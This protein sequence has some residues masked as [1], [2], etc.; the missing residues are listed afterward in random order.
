MAPAL[1][2]RKVVLNF[3]FKLWLLT[4]VLSLALGPLNLLL[5]PLFCIFVV[6]LDFDPWLRTMDFEVTW[7]GPLADE[8]SRVADAVTAE[9]L[10]ERGR[11]REVGFSCVTPCG[12]EGKREQSLYSSQ[13]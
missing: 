12:K 6:K 7:S 13:N 4:N 11:V 3:A 5:E 10:D 8:L 1:V 2:T 9:G